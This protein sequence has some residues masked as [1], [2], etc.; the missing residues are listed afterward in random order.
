MS[1]ALQTRALITGIEAAIQIA[2][3]PNF[4]I[5]VG[6]PRVPFA[7]NSFAVILW[8]PVTIEFGG[9]VGS[10]SRPGQFN[11]F[12][13]TGRWPFPADKT[14][15]LDLL[16]VDKANLLIAQLQMGPVFAN[17]GGF[18][19]VTG[20]S[21]SETDDPNE[22]VYEVTLTFSCYTIADHH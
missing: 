3:G 18:P 15:I 16:K 10:V 11:V 12:T 4:P 5:A 7:Q 22:K 21:P 2:W 9:K 13:I 17:I 8:E 20:V 14:Q 1:N 6:Q 19:L